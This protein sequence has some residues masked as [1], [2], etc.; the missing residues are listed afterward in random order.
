MN[1]MCDHQW[2][3]RGSLNEK[4][5]KSLKLTLHFDKLLWKFVGDANARVINKELEATCEVYSNQ[6]LTNH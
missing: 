2:L 4:K 1:F 6:G 5:K 3:T